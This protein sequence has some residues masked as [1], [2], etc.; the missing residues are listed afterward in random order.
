MPA[1]KFIC[2]NGN[3]IKISE[4]LKTCPNSQRCM[5]LPTLRAVANSLDRK[6][7]EPTVTELIAGTRETYYSDDKK[8]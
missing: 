7:S 6:L 3:K 2:P 8:S 1:T 5:F 4:C